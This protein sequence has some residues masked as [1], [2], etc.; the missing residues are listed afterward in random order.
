MDNTQ[1]R[2]KLFEGAKIYE[3]S[4]GA[5]QR[6]YTIVRVTETQAISETGIKFKIELSGSGTATQ[7]AKNKWDFCTHYLETPELKLKLWR[8]NAISKC[9]KADFSKFSNEQLQ[10]VLNILNATI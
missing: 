9:S 8:Q 1:E 4:R 5:I 6:V 2:S 3:V 7:L 10:A